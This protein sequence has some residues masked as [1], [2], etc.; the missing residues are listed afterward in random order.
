MAFSLI[1]PA[2]T[3][4]RS[5]IHAALI[6]ALVVLLAASGAGIT[7]ALWASQA[8]VSSSAT[9][10]TLAVSTTNFTSG[11][12]T[13]GNHAL[14]TRSSVTVS[15]TTTTSSTTPANIAVSLDIAGGDAA[16][17]SLVTVQMWR[18]TTGTNCTTATPS[19][20]VRNGTW[21]SFTS[22]TETGLLVAGASAQYCLSSS[23]AERS[24]VATASG[25]LSIQPRISA[26]ATVGNFSASATATTTQTTSH[27]YP[28]TNQPAAHT[29]FQIRNS[30]TTRCVDVEGGTLGAGTTVIDYPCKT[31]TGSDT[32]NQDWSISTASA[33]PRYVT[34]AT[35]YNQNLLIGSTDAA[36]T[37]GT[38]IQVQVPASGNHQQWQLQVRS[39]TAGVSTFQ[40]VNRASGLC[41]QASSAGTLT[42]QACDG[43][44]VQGFTMTNRG[45]ESPTISSL[46]CADTTGPS[47][48][49][50]VLSWTQPAFGAYTIQAQRSGSTW[51]TVGTAPE[52]AT[53]FTMP[54]A[55]SQWTAGT[56]NIR[57]TY[58]GQTLASS[59]VW[60]GMNGTEH[61]LRCAAPAAS[62]AGIVCASTPTGV[63]YTW[64]EP[65]V[66]AYTFQARQGSGTWQDIAEAASG[67]M[68]VTSSSV[69]TFANGTADLRVR[70]NGSTLASAITTVWKGQLAQGGAAVLQ[71][72][73]PTANFTSL[74]CVNS[75]SN[76][77]AIG[78]G[79]PAMGTYTIS[80]QTGS[81]WTQVTTA[82]QWATS[83][84]FSAS[85][86]WPAGTTTLRVLYGSESATITVQKSNSGNTHILRCIAPPL[87]SGTP[88]GGDGYYAS[89]S[90][91]LAAVTGAEADFVVLIDGVVTDIPVRK[92]GEWT[93]QMWATPTNSYGYT[94]TPGTRTIEVR[95]GSATGELIMSAPVTFS[96]S[97]NGD[98]RVLVFP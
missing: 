12:F 94:A 30:S 90:W 95:R 59:T 61:R 40:I 7:F 50:V 34:I 49:T 9:A 24:S 68:S 28:A 46:M 4:R 79:H 78:W 10:A 11:A 45:L 91:P 86:A 58:N 82:A 84:T 53:S 47:N 5:M 70:Y 76:S 52:D 37:A 3:S 56:R 98:G 71:C 15:N 66:G 2:F 27:I 55:D 92:W 72:A 80:R 63:A 25:T 16:L 73:A 67:A 74:S 22:F 57:V 69:G 26:V 36:T 88:S 29:W 44:A 14:S 64:S 31:A 17:A 93:L 18:V 21:A 48:Q 77:V 42:Q 87:V 23:I 85:S 1:R 8:T 32:F 51:T 33:D 83:A 39:T 54:Q 19:G 13:F 97:P 60:K 41:L 89:W 20:T 81:G 6:G 38:G 43:S 65:A 75:G 96:T 62:V 35:R